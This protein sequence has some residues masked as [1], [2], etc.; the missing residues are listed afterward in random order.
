MLSVVAVGTVESV[1][2]RGMFPI[3]QVEA[4]RLQLNW[5]L[6]LTVLL[7]FDTCLNK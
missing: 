5:G 2:N 1:V 4:V 6:L 3:V 7:S